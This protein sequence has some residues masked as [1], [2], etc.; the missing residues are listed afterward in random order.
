[1]EESSGRG[2]KEAIKMFDVLESRILMDYEVI[3][4]SDL[5]V[6]GHRESA[7]GEMEMGVLKDAEGNPIIPGSSLKGVLRSEMEKLLKGLGKHTCTPADL[8]PAGE[9]CTVCLLFGG[10]EYAGSI[11]IRDAITDTRK[12][13]VRDGVRID[14]AKRKAAEEALYQLEV[15]PRGAIFRGRIT[16][17]NPKIKLKIGENEEEYRYAKLGA[18]LGTIRFFNATSRSLGGGVSRG[19]GEVLIVPKKI[20]EVTA[21]DYLN[22]KYKG[23]EIAKLGDVKDSEE[24]LEEGDDAK[25]LEEQLEEGELPMTPQGRVEKFIEDWKKYVNKLEDKLK[26]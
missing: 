20:R 21:G 17:E 16:I 7:P 8:C 14:R 15:V 13:L 25:E 6:G 2:A 23:E 1:M 9:E 4:K 18:L 22:G 19:F 5:H 11:R 3:V 26:K 24:Q 12:T 10:K